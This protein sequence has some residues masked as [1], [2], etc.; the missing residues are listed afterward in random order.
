MSTLMPTSTTMQRVNICDAFA[1]AVVLRSTGD[2][3]SIAAVHA[4]DGTLE[5]FG[6]SQSECRAAEASRSTQQ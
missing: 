5:H 1:F 4:G 2:F 6:Y 3:V